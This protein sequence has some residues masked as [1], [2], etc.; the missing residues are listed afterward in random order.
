LNVTRHQTLGRH[1]DTLGRHYVSLALISPRLDIFDKKLRLD[2]RR[3]EAGARFIKLIVAQAADQPATKVVLGE[4]CEAQCR[5]LPLERD[6]TPSYPP[7]EEED[8]ARF[9]GRSEQHLAEER[10]ARA[11]EYRSRSAQFAFVAHW[12]LVPTADHVRSENFMIW[13]MRL[14]DHGRPKR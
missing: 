7:W 10:K 13:L 2:R 14:P 12:R 8:N 4:P 3:A 5:R 11:E 1:R 6:F 9:T